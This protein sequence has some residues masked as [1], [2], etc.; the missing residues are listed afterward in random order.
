MK[1]N[2]WSSAEIRGKPKLQPKGQN[3]WLLFEIIDGGDG[4]MP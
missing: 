1:Y 2:N 4:G 3:Y